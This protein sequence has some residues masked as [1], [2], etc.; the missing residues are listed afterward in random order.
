MYNEYQLR[1]VGEMSMFPAPCFRLFTV[2]E[3]LPCSG[4][5]YFV[6]DHIESVRHS[7]E[8]IAGVRPPFHL[9]VTVL[10]HPSHN[11]TTRK[12]FPCNYTGQTHQW[13]ERLSL[14]KGRGSSKIFLV[15][16][17]LI[18]LSFS[19]TIPFLPHPTAIPFSF[20]PNILPPSYMH[21]C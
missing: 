1:Q 21:D 4:M 7:R 15:P 2:L 12:N 19:H 16:A 20:W 9:L 3:S 17:C 6:Q 13:K 11:P 10:H 14:E 5:K 18:L 8:I